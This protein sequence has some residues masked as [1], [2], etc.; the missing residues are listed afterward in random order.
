M[1]RNNQ[2]VSSNKQASEVAEAATR[3]LGE[4]ASVISA[5]DAMGKR[6]FFPDGIRSLNIAVKFGGAEV[7]L[8]V[9]GVAGDSSLELAARSRGAFRAAG[10]VQLP[11]GTAD[12]YTYSAPDRQYGTQK[13]IDTVQEVAKAIHA[14][15]AGLTFS[16]GDISFVD[17]A[18]M[19]PHTAHR[20]GRNID[21]RP[22]RKD[23][24]DKPVSYK[25]ADYDRSA[26]NVVI[27]EYL[28]HANVTKVIFND[29]KISG[30]QGDGGTGHD[31]HF[32]V[33][34]SV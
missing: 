15:N 14:A 21:I 2:A 26:T 20:L 9:E 29:S 33:E 27:Q 18:P 25:S 1:T 17:G 16:V 24:Q 3:V 10:F 12:F 31:D 23:G 19:P 7:S 34:I 5:S 4:L 8:S 6:I 32:H 22:I 11:Q 13:A 28:A 30:V